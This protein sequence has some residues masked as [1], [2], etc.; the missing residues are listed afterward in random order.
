M[1]LDYIL[2]SFP[3]SMVPPSPLLNPSLLFTSCSLCKIVRIAYHAAKGRSIQCCFWLPI[4]NKGTCTQCPE[5]VM[6]CRW[7][8][9]MSWF[10]PQEPSLGGT[11]LELHMGHPQRE[12]M[13]SAA[14]IWRGLL[15]LELSFSVDA[16]VILSEALASRTCRCLLHHRSSP[17][18][19][20][21]TPGTF[22]SQIPAGF[23]EPRLLVVMDPR[24]DYQPLIEA[25]YANLPTML[26]V[27][28][29]LLCSVC[30]LLP[31]QQQKG[32]SSVCPMWWNLAWEVL[33]LHHLLW[34]PVGDHAQSTSAETPRR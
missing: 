30:T 15:R 18:A 21:F 6:F 32:A 8:K 13:V 3:F 10:L 24:A 14:Q 28:Q 22:T 23:R 12:G 2:R 4:V 29:I 31:R 1:Y 26:R 20:G 17:I 19:G 34:A 16:Y 27:T 5:S 9:W 33:C 11:N 25:S 7:R